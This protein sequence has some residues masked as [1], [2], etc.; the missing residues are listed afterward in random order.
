VGVLE[1]AGVLRLVLRTQP[2][3]EDPVTR[4]FGHHSI[5]R[6]FLRISRGIMRV[7][8]MNDT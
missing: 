5:G 8:M 2:R 7:K 4:R 6:I 1:M 3:S